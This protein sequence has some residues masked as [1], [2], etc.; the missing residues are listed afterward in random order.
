MI[1]LNTNTQSIWDCPGM[2][3]DPYISIFRRHEV[4]L[5]IAGL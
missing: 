2:Y 4:H 3:N 5:A 1:K